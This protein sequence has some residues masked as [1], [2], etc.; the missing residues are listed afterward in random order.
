MLKSIILGV[1]DAIEPKMAEGYTVDGR[2]RVEQ[3]LGSGSYGR[4]YRVFDNKQ[5][6]Q[7][8]LKALRLQKRLSQRN[9][10]S[11]R[12]ETEL[13]RGFIHPAF[14]R[15]YECGEFNKIPYFTMEYINGKTFEQLI[16]SEG[17]IYNEN[18]ALSVAMKLNEI[19]GYLH[20]Q[21]IVH[22][23][24]RIPNIM[25]VGDELKLIDFGLAR[26]LSSGTRHPAKKPAKNPYREL[27]VCSDFY[28]LGH[29]LLFLLYS[30]YTPEHEQAEERS[31]EDELQISLPARQ[32]IRRL[33][34]LDEPYDDWRYVQEELLRIT[35]LQAMS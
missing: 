31:W 8:V 35:D 12:N 14:P 23:D 28:G 4:S 13:L 16:F 25:I 1:S 24:V 27:S 33:L 30:G 29:F 26:K 18:E 6:C 34:Q 5:G 20:S 9:I 7:A 19:I 32:L 10:S 3:Y 17:R 2:Y 22:R 11:F 15:F 21:Q